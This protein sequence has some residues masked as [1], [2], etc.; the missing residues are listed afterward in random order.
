MG[1]KEGVSAE[2]ETLG[3]ALPPLNY[4]TCQKITAALQCHSYF[5]YYPH[6]PKMLSG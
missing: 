1:K 4:A 6:T 2:V 5:L 3:E